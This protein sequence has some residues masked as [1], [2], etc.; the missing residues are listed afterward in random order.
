MT[1]HESVDE[2][3]VEPTRDGDRPTAREI[4]DLLGD[5]RRMIDAAGGWAHRIPPEQVEAWTARKRDLLAR[6]A[7]HRDTPDLGEHDRE[8]EEPGGSGLEW[9]L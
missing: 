6:I 4:A 9:S 2:Q 8:P 5:Y 3:I 1:D 7:A